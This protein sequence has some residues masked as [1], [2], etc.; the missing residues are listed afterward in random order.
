[1]KPDKK[2][3]FEK[4]AMGDNG[5]DMSVAQLAQVMIKQFDEQKKAI[6]DLTRSFQRQFDDFNERMDRLDR[7]P[8]DPQR[9]ICITGLKLKP[10]RAEDIQL[11]DIFESVGAGCVIVNTRRMRSY[12]G[13]P[14]MIKCELQSVEDKINILQCKMAIKEQI[15]SIWIRSSK[16]HADRVLEDNFATILSLLPEGHKF[17]T[18]SDGRIIL[19]SQYVEWEA[20][21]QDQGTTG[22]SA[23][24]RST[25][26]V[27]ENESITSASTAV[28]GA[29]PSMQLPSQA[30]HTRPFRAGAWRGG[31][32][33]RESR[34]RG[35][36]G[37][38]GFQGSYRGHRG[39][40]GSDYRGNQRGGHPTAWQNTPE[41]RPKNPLSTVDIHDEFPPLQPSAN[42]NTPRGSHQ[43]PDKKRVRNSS[44]E[45]VTDTDITQDTNTDSKAME[46]TTQIHVQTNKENLEK[47][48]ND[49]ESE[50][51]QSSEHPAQMNGNSK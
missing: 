43:P 42:T 39:Q 15:P 48:D 18:A 13:K 50:D 19:K 30:R 5:E 31:Y 38:A 51:K 25:R 40:R 20:E 45:T 26:G 17:K 36:R 41:V 1:M 34:G 4:G 2:T 3:T 22:P 16:S 24:S 44:S 33:G 28:N 23:G 49:S 11:S 32:R 8:F 14:G 12:D 47:K 46:L 6:G 37:R 21:E 10:D 27:A 29:S 35:Q 7:I 9:T